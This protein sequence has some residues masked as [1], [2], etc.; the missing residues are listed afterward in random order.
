MLHNMRIISFYLLLTAF[1]L[2]SASQIMKL[3]LSCTW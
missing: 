1:T 2:L 3:V